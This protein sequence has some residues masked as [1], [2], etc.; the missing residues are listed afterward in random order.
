MS[1]MCD[2]DVTGSAVKQDAPA[3]SA[4]HRASVLFQ[5]RFKNNTKADQSYTMRTEKK[6]RTSMSTSVEHGF[7]KGVEMGVR[8]MTP[9]EVSTQGVVPDWQP[10]QLSSDSQSNQKS[11]YC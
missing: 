1:V 10:S 6:T 8:L 3:T 9:G 2:V 11:C 7:T 4:D 5:T